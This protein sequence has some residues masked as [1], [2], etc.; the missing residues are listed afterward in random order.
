MPGPANEASTV[1]PA[2][3]LVS[4]ANIVVEGNE[5]LVRKLAADAISQAQLIDEIQSGDYYP[6]PGSY[7]VSHQRAVSKTSLRILADVL[8]ELAPIDQG[9]AAQIVD[10]AKPVSSS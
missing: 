4:R 10:T 8:D 9:W 3:E 1:S 6:T 5:A 2:D 7:D